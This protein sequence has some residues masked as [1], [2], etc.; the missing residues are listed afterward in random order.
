M[1]KSASAAFLS[2]Q[3]RRSFRK[4]RGLERIES[5]TATT[6]QTLK[7]EFSFKTFCS[8]HAGLF[9]VSVLADFTGANA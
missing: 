2:T 3:R 7:L 4:H 6:L 9:R 5:Q 1:L 8:F